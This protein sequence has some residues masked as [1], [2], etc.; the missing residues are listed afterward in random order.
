ME[1]TDLLSQDQ[2]IQGSAQQVQRIQ[3]ISR[4]FVGK[5]NQDSEIRQW[6]RKHIH[7]VQ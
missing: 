5:K 6:W 7:R 3:S 2:V 1:D 4:E